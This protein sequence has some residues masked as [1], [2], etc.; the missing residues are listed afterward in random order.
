LR[1]LPPVQPSLYVWEALLDLT[2]LVE[3]LDVVVTKPLV[4]ASV[5]ARRARALGLEQEPGKQRDNARREDERD[6]ITP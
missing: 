6:D 5:P 1:Q 4:L 3:G 2:R